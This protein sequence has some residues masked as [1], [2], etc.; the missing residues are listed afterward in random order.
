MSEG[1]SRTLLFLG[2]STKSELTKKVIRRRASAP[3]ILIIK[4]RH[5]KQKMVTPCYL[6]AAQKKRYAEHL[7]NSIEQ[8]QTVLCPP[9]CCALLTGAIPAART[10]Q[11]Q[12]T[13]NRTSTSTPPTHTRAANARGRSVS[14]A[15]HTH[16]VAK[17][18][19][20][21]LYSARLGKIQISSVPGTLTVQAASCPA[22]PGTPAS[23][24]GTPWRST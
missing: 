13:R 5:K 14:H 15:I 7:H 23:C 24:G 3:L 4:S 18:Q 2:C 19:P 1:I 11:H 21:A 12:L 20:I 17:A 10:R 16:E 22:T 8:P 6:E 9:Y